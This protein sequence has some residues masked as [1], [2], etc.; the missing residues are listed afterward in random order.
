MRIIAYK[1]MITLIYDAKCKNSRAIDMLRSVSS[2]MG[3][4]KLLKR[5]ISLP[6]I[7]VASIEAG[8]HAI[9]DLETKILRM[10]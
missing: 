10:R 2:S 5:L 8:G 1:R 7:A 9:R 4:D 6:Q 3:Q